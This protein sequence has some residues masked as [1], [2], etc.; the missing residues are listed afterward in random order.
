MVLLRV[1]TLTLV[2]LMLS[3]GMVTN[4][5]LVWQN[6]VI[7]LRTGELLKGR[8][9]LHIT[10]RADVAYT[11]GCDKRPLEQFI[12]FATGG[13]KELQ[14]WIQRAVGYTL[15]GLN[16]QDVMFLVYGPPGSGKNTFVEAIVK[17]HEYSAVRVAT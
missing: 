6:G 2:L 12:D 11:E 7:D 9:D 5:F 4:I 13:D 3:R 10:K 8:P 1:L 15:T 16:N 14:D 17:A